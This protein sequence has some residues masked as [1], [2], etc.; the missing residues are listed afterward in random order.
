MYVTQRYILLQIYEENTERIDNKIFWKVSNSNL[1]RS[2]EAYWNILKPIS[3][4]LDTLQRKGASLSDALE[5]WKNSQN[6][7]LVYL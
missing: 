2:T 6:I 1:K 3:I 4:D 5:Q 7:L